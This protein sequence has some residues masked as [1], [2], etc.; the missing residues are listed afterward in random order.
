MARVNKEKLV[1][2]KFEELSMDEM[3][4]VQGSGDIG[5]EPALMGNCPPKAYPTLANLRCIL[6]RWGR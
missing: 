3:A 2:K 5:A 6:K 1:G 4:M